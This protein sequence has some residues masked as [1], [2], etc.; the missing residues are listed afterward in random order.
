MARDER[1]AE[2]AQA[3]VRPEHPREAGLD[4]PEGDLRGAD[5]TRR[6]LLCIAGRENK[7]AWTYG[8]KAV[9]V[10]GAEGFVA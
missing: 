9:A 4:Q 8:A 6:S 2:R 10:F 7:E 5:E 3:G 1:L